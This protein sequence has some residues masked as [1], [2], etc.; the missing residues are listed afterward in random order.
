MIILTGALG[1]L[2]QLRS[3][4]YPSKADKRAK[5]TPLLSIF[6]SPH[7]DDPL[8]ANFPAIQRRA[9]VLRC[10]HDLEIR[11]T[12]EPILRGLRFQDSSR[13]RERSTKE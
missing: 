6:Q 5:G 10:R 4:P 12:R 7:S 9:A 2:S 8:K 1:V 3:I 13:I 11:R